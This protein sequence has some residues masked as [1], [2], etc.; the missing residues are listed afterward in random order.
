MNLHSTLL[1]YLKELKDILRDR[2]TLLS[3]L[4]FPIVLMPVM[5]IGMAKFMVSRMAKIHEER[6]IVAWLSTGESDDLQYRLSS[7]EGMDIMTELSDSAAAVEL[8]LDKSIDAV[9][10]VPAGF[11]QS[12]DLF[13]SGQSHDPPRNIAL[14]SDDTR[15]KSQFAARRISDVIKQYRTDLVTN[16]LTTRGL[17]PE[18]MKPFDLVRKNIASPKQMGRYIAGSFL[19]YIVILMALT[20]AMYPAIDLTAG[21]KERG[22]LETLL[23]SGVSRLDIVLGKFLTVFTASIITASLAIGSMT[24]TGIGLLGL[25]PEISSE[26]NF[27]IEPVSVILMVMAMIPLGALFA[28]LLMTL[29]LFAKS[30]REAQSY[31]SPLMIIVI[32]PAMASLIPDTELSKELAFVPVLNVSMMMKDALLGSVDAG[33]LAVTMGVNIILAALGLLLVLRMFQRESVLFRI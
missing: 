14:Y 19:P 1:I 32:I 20:G 16:S 26:L 6:S 15:E 33:S 7:L 23:V 21:E 22:T 4:L 12:L 10:I 3:M 9:V 2:R 5:S 30:Y 17:P 8:L 13:L 11:F 31:I 29:S 28:S 18:L 25:T 27:S 24:V